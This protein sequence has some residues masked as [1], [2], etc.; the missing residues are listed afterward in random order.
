MAVGDFGCDG[1]GIVVGYRQL[2]SMVSAGS[3]PHSTRAVVAGLPGLTSRSWK[4]DRGGSREALRSRPPL[5][6]VK[7]KAQP[8]THHQKEY[9]EFVEA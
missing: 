8:V 9:K 7:E 5:S 1:G 2:V 6:G 4:R 3:H